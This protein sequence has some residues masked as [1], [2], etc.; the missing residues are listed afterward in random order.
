MQKIRESTMEEVFQAQMN[1]IPLVPP[2]EEG[3]VD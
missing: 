1:Y 2:L 3:N